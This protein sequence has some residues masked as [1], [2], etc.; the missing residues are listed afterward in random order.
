MT[1]NPIRRST[2]KDLKEKAAKV[3]KNKTLVNEKL[4]KGTWVDKPAKPGTRFT[5]A[6]S[7]KADPS[8]LSDFDIIVEKLG[9]VKAHAFERAIKEWIDAN[10]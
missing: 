9:M 6:F 8:V 5:Q 1:I 4:I 2:P 7:V 3:A 10:K